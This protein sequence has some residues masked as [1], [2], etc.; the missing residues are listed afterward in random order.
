MLDI[1]DLSK[2]GGL[3]TIFICIILIAVS[4][5]FLGIVHF[6][7]A[8]TDAALR[9]SDCVIENNSLVDSCQ[10][11][12]EMSIY[13][14]LGLRHLFV[15]FSFFFIFTTVLALLML[16]YQSGRSPALLGIFT[17]FVM[18][19]TYISIEMANIYI[20]FLQNEIFRTIMLEF[21]VYN[22]VMIKFP[23]FVFIISL[24]SV[25]IGIVNWQKTKV[26][27]PTKTELDY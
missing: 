20:T 21:T 11:L 19:M 12:F 10:E 15:W 1:E 2:Y 14:F 4:G 6:T 5:V 7:M 18:L 22:K 16:G 24:F 23:W 25:M 3:Y 9:T 17:A 8:A 27:E 13:P 26:N